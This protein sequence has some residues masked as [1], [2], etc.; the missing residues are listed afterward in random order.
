MIRLGVDVGN[1]GCKVAGYDEAGRMVALAR[2]EY[3]FASRGVGQREL[4]AESIFALVLD[5]LAEVA[6][7]GVGRQ[8]G[9]LAVSSQGEAII[10]MDSAGRSLAP[11]QAS[12]DAR[13][14]GAVAQVYSQVDGTALEAATG[15]PAHGMFSLYK[16]LTLREFEPELYRRIRRIACF[17]DWVAHRL[18]ADL[19]MDYSLASRT[20]MLD[21]S[22]RAW[23]GW[24]LAGLDLDPGL[25]PPLAPSGTGIGTLSADM[26]ARTGLSPQTVIATGGHDQICCSLGAGIASP[27][28]AMNSMGTTDTVLALASSSDKAAQIVGRGNA[29]GL[30]ALDGYVLH[31]YVMSTGSTTAWFG[32]TFQMG[33][34]TLSSMAAAAWNGGKPSGIHF[35]PHMTGSG[36]PYLDVASTGLFAGLSTE[37]TPALMYRSVLEGMCFELK[38]NLDLLAAAGAGT[39]TVTVL[40]GAAESDHYL[41]LKADIFGVPVQRAAVAEAGCLGAALLAGQAEESADSLAET[42]AQMRRLDQTFDPDLGR[43]QAYADLAAV[44]RRLYAASQSLAGG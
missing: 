44:H 43:H 17:A 22:R 26:A 4:D 36:T 11:I 9:A 33:G 39:D 6:A 20:S 28:Q 23:C 37:S 25:L 7:G 42:V 27:G 24:L 13:S 32:R 2:R 8:V 16:L 21:V 30:G 14:A 34:H 15:N 38:D 29:I 41:Q 19:V 18:G 40:G 31:G 35:L 1:S 3:S 12:F 10:P 5:C